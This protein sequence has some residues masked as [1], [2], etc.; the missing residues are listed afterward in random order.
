MPY[1]DI[2]VDRAGP[3]MWLTFNRPDD[4][5]AI[6][7][8]MAEQ[9]CAAV[10]QAE[11]DRDCHVLVLQGAGRFFCAGGD[12]AMMA[13]AADPA[14]FLGNL[15]R[16]MHAGLLRLAESNLVTIA[17][18]HGTAAGAGLGLVLN[19]DVVLASPDARFLTAYGSVGLTPDC[20]VSYLLP[21][22]VGPRRAAAMALLGRAVTADEA[23]AWG[24]A[25]EVLPA[26]R[27]VERAEELGLR[28]GS[29]ATHVLGPTKRLL[30]G[31]AAGET[32]GER[33][34]QAAGGYAAH[35]AAEAATIADFVTHP[36]T[37]ESLAAFVSKGRD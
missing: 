26:E 23:E 31:A 20:G 35:L 22:V 29:G 32:A 11:Q 33:A 28:A 7:T 18:V 12:V 2:L 19:A 13:N 34:G 37:K 27:L 24:L 9:F 4:A 17:V 16:T 30:A 36:R 8:A 25:T 14:L 3:I 15:A 21:R 5:N 6:S 10:E 1:T